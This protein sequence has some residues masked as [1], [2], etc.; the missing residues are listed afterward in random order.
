MA[1]IRCKESGCDTSGH[2]VA[3]L[4]C[5]APMPGHPKQSASASVVVATRREKRGWCA[6]VATSAITLI[7]LCACSAGDSGIDGGQ[8]AAAA[9]SS[10]IDSQLPPQSNPWRVIGRQGQGARF[11]VI[12][13]ALASDKA[14]YQRA[15]QAECPA[16]W[17]QAMF[18]VEGTRAASGIPMSQAQ[19]RAQTALYRRNAARG[20]SKFT[21]RC[22]AFPDTSDSECFTVD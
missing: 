5:Q 4:G 20:L 15:A 12:D 14:V 7:S 6:R 17:C 13:K 10:R 3:R 19:S 18:W 16:D 11:I 22:D 8:S 9:P 21:W 2:A 1:L